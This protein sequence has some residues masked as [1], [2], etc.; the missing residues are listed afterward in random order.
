MAP[1]DMDDL[2][3]CYISISWNKFKVGLPWNGLKA[4]RGKAKAERY[5]K[6]KV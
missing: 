6:E 4:G 2:E 5:G 3:Q 1:N